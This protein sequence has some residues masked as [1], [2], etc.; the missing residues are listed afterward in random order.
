KNKDILPKTE[1]LVLFDPLPIDYFDLYKIVIDFAEVYSPQKTKESR[2]R[3]KQV[4]DA[5]NYDLKFIKLGEF[6]KQ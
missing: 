3:Y 6:L 1:A 2:T 4:R 5:D